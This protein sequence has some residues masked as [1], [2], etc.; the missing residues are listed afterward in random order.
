M[1]AGIITG[2]LLR[3]RNN[4]YLSKVITVLIWLL[5]FLLGVE[6]GGNETIVSQFSVLG[7]EAFVLTIAGLAG[8]ILLAWILWR[9]VRAGKEDER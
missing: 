9:I 6:V 1:A 8:S 7:F 4:G 3:K 5:L 2:R